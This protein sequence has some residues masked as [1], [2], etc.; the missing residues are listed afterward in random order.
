MANLSLLGSDGSAERTVELPDVPVTVGGP[1]SDRVLPGLASGTLRFHVAEGLVERPA[2]SAELRVDGR[3]VERASLADGLVIEWAGLRLRFES[4][5][6]LDQVA[7]PPAPAPEAWQRLKA[8]LLAEMGRADKKAA[9]RWQEAVVAGSFNSAAAAAEIN[10]ASGVPDED[11][12]LVERAGRLGRDL[13]M[14]PTLRGAR[15]AARAT[16]QAGRNVFAYALTQLVI[17]LF[18]AFVFSIG[19]LVARFQGVELDGFLD[20][21]LDVVLFRG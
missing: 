10:A 3:T 11:P 8:G 21:V 14:Q 9:K 19:L 17:V 2:G 4:E 6:T 18:F 1:G 12:A 5:A 13:L 7:L 15:G 16:R 20:S